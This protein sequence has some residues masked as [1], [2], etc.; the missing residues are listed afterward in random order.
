MNL[1]NSLKEEKQEEIKKLEKEM[2]AYNI[3]EEEKELVRKGEYNPRDF[4]PFLSNI[5][6]VFIVVTTKN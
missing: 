6:V 1:E 2:E 5:L 4:T 3:S